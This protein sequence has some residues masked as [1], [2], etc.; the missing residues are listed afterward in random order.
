MARTMNRPTPE[1]NE[2]LKRSGSNN[3]EVACASQREL[4]VA[5]TLPLRQGV[6]KGDI[7]AGIYEPV[8]FEPGAA[9]EFPLDFLAPGSEKDFIAYT[10]PG[11][12]KIPE[13]HVEGDFVMVPTYETASSIDF[14][15]KYLR[16]ARWDVMGRAM[17]VLEASFVRKQNQDGWR[18]ILASGVGRALVVYDDNAPKGLFS[19]RLV[20][21][22]KTVMRRFAGGNST[23]VNRGKLTDMY[24]S[25]EG[26]E[27]IR[28]WDLTQVDDF[29]RR[30]IFL[31]AGGEL[32]E[33][34]LTRIFGVNLH[35]IDE[36]GVNQEFQNYFTNVLGGTMPSNKQEILVG[37]D[38]SKDDCFVQ[39]VRQELEMFEDPTFHRQRRGGFYGWMEAG[40][41]ALDSRRSLVLSF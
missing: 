1:M 21:L 34:S 40:Y 5:L 7:L 18:T 23:S 26:L 27:D 38:L 3:Y 6:L 35:D 28:S 37:L 32:G 15:L 25:P 8:A 17:Q 11:Q 30:E 12:G 39:P 10:I 9:V 13:R 4:A 20:A 22:G 19:K 41:C 36:M 16:D 24:L 14:A 31:N 33:D 29:T 2:L